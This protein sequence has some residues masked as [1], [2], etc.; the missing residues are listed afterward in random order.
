MLFEEYSG[1]N[2]LFVIEFYVFFKTA[3]C[4]ASKKLQSISFLL[5]F[6]IFIVHV[7]KKQGLMIHLSW[8]NAWSER[9]KPQIIIPPAFCKPRVVAHSCNPALGG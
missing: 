7:C 5:I 2:K 1:R 3:K 9:I 4:L 8:Q 6:S